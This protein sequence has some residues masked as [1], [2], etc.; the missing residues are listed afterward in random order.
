MISHDRRFLENL[1]AARCGSTAGKP[2]R[3]ERGFAAFEAWRDDVLIE[4]ER[5]QH[6]LDARSSPRNTGCATGVTGVASE[7][8]RRLRQSARA[9][10]GAAR[11]SRLGRQAA[12]A[13]TAADRSGAL[14]I[15]AA[16][17]SKSY[18]GRPIVTDFS[19]RIRRGDRIGI[20]GPTAPARPPCSAY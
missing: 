16:R 15:E 20:V 12:L 17:I 13:A 7:N 9:A 2:G 11:L 10:P 4:E 1:S 14:V 8:M 18:D 6:K 3:I 5:E 19:T